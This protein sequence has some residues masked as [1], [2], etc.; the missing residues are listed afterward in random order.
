MRRCKIFHDS[1][2]R[3]VYDTLFLTSSFLSLDASS[4]LK[5]AAA[6]S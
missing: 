2:V 5:A 4:A 3:N 1:N 6:D